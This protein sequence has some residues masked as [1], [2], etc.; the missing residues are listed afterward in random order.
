M[1]APRSRGYGSD[2]S[3]SSPSAAGVAPAR[4]KRPPTIRTRNDASTT[5]GSPAPWFRARAALASTP[6]P[7][8]P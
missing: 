2:M 7:A 5:S 3:A 1:I 8:M 6:P 4:T